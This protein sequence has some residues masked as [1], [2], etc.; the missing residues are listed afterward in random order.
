MIV[1]DEEN[2]I[3]PSV[4]PGVVLRELGV[5]RRHL[6][7]ESSR[8]DE[9]KESDSL[10]LHL[11]SVHVDVEVGRVEVDDGRHLVGHE[12]VE[13]LGNVN[14][15]ARVEDEWGRKSQIE[16]SEG[17]GTKRENE[18]GGREDSHQL[19]ERLERSSESERYVHGRDLGEVGGEGSVVV[20]VV[21]LP[22]RSL[23]KRTKEGREGQIE[24]R[25]RVL[26]TR[27]VRR[28]PW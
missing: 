25:P 23:S 1:R 3:S 18:P 20:R 14:L 27:K 22:R 26:E 8:I 12:V 11:L 16:K 19:L 28:T 7:E 6:L 9:G 24:T 15:T 13:D 5:P 17:K 2:V 21:P 10:P 4:P